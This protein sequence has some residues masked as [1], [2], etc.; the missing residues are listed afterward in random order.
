MNDTDR[1][2]ETSAQRAENQQILHRRELLEHHSN[3]LG[4]IGGIL[5]VRGDEL[6]VRLGSVVI[7]GLRM[8]RIEIAT[9]VIRKKGF[10]EC[11]GEALQHVR[12]TIGTRTTDRLI[13]NVFAQQV[14]EAIQ[15]IIENDNAVVGRSARVQKRIRMK[16]VTKHVVFL[17]E[18]KANLSLFDA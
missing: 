16:I 12:A 14:S 2:I 1:V 4:E 8:N 7:T 5:V 10:V 13:P 11:I 18:Q 3:T 9:D 15:R 17:F 6:D